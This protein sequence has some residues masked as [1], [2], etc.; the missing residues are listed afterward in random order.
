MKKIIKESILNTI[1]IYNTMINDND[2]IK[3][4]EIIAKKIV[5]TYK[6]NK[7]VLIAGNGGSAADAQH[8]A[9]ELVNRFNFDRHALSAIA[10]T[11]DSSV[12]TCIA[13]DINFNEVF[14][15][16]IEANGCKGDVFIGISTS[17]NS[18]NIINAIQKCKE[19]GIISIG[20]TGISN[21]MMDKYCDYIIKVPSTSTP[22]IQEGHLLIEH[23][24]CA[25]VEEKIYGKNVK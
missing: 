10:L 11:T 25:L 6:N 18:K 9:G 7:K 24:L 1:G 14:A 23:I 15:R 20:L 21:S 5:D 4:I 2:F 22:R 16:Q 17:G 8:I 12:L 3:N 13:N 19:K